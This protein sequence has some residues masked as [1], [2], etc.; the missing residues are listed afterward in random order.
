MGGTGGYVSYMAAM[1][2]NC[3]LGSVRSEAL[4]SPFAP[5]T[6]NSV[7]GK[8]NFL[9]FRGTNL[10]S[11]ITDRF[12]PRENRGSCA[13]T[14]MFAPHGWR[15]GQRTMFAYR[16]PRPAIH[17]RI[18]T[19]VRLDRFREIAGSNP[20]RTSRYTT[21]RHCRACR[22]ARSHWAQSCLQASSL[23]GSWPSARRT[24]QPMP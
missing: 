23:L 7:A 9:S 12:W 20:R 24:S 14:R 11:K 8:S 17:A 22:I 3:F 10:G 1:D 4:E 18:R 6:I 5:G 13:G 15:I 21:P 2:A 19:M 16:T